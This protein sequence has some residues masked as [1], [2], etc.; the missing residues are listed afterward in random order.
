MDIINRF[1]ELFGINRTTV[2]GAMSEK[3][4]LKA[5]IDFL[6]NR[7]FTKITGRQLTSHDISSLSRNQKNLDDLQKL[8]PARRLRRGTLG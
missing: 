4:E 5:Q 3:S 7:L 1:L 6:R 8:S 2:T